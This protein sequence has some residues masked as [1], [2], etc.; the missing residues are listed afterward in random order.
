[1]TQPLAEALP[2]RSADTIEPEVALAG[3]VSGEIEQS[4][5]QHGSFWR[6]AA[7]GFAIPFVIVAVSIFG[8]ME[9]RGGLPASA[10]AGA[11]SATVALPADRLYKAVSPSVFLVTVKNDNQNSASLG[12][13]FLVSA[14]GLVVTNFHVIKGGT[15]A[16]IQTA[17][18]CQQFV[19]RGV[20]AVDPDGDLALLQT[21]ATGSPLSIGS[22]DPPAIGSRVYA[23]GSPEGFTN[24]LSEG[25][26]SGLRTDDQSQIPMLQTTA[27]ISHGSSG[28]P[29]LTADARVVG[30]T[31]EFWG[32][33]QNLN[34][35]VTASRIRRLIAARG[36]LTALS[37]A[38][39]GY[40]APA[41][42]GDE[43]GSAAED[44]KTLE[45][46]WTAL[47]QKQLQDAA[48]MLA[49][50]Q[51]RQADNT[52]FWYLS[53]YLQEQLH[54]YGQTGDSH[55][56]QAAGIGD[57]PRFLSSRSATAPTT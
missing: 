27:P 18:L 43:P 44:N 4:S 12:S 53:G 11:P 55:L 54:D 34:L 25:I 32:E 26:I 10:D 41:G 20:V 22:D 9:L 28:G 15:S 23:I 37:V 16:T 49:T 33:G 38:N 57:C 3:V 30:V 50:V 24:T 47:N 8:F 13:G 48:D 46:I 17:D 7:V 51:E 36:A 42:Q 29:L 35:A 5:H 19:V 56:F 6:K 52:R 31:S 40:G 2:D 39:D 1:L 45:N 21:D 14:D